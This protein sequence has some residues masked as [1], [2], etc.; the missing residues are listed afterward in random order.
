MSKKKKDWKT[1]KERLLRLDLEERRKEY[2]RQDYISLDNILTWREE[3]RSN[4]KEEGKDLTGGGGLSEKVSL[5]K[6]DITVLEVD[7]IVNADRN[8][9]GPMALG[10]GVAAVTESKYPVSLRRK[11]AMAVMYSI[12]IMTLM[13][14]EG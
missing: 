1:E 14:R 6:G 4:D 11:T 12:V 10:A 5:Y 13:D 2:R 9:D 7:A 8:T 3:K